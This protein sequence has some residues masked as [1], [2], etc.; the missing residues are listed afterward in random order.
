MTWDMAWNLFTGALGAFAMIA[1]VVVF[2]IW[3]ITRGRRK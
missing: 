1:L 2:T 3:L